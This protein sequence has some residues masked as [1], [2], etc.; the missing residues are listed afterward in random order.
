MSDFVAA[1]VAAVV[2]A[3]VA[4]VTAVAAAAVVAVAAVLADGRGCGLGRDRS[5]SR[6]SQAAKSCRLMTIKTNT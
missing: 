5:T 4:A 2:A 1:V 6:A 3:A